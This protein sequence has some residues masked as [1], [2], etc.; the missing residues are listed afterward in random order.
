[1]GPRCSCLCNKDN[2]N[3]YNFY[4]ESAY[5]QL[6]ED[7]P[8]VVKAHKNSKS[9]DIK[10]GIDNKYNRNYFHIDNKSKILDSS[11]SYHKDYT[12]SD[13]KNK[14]IMG[15]SVSDFLNKNMKC[16][17]KIQA[18]A[19]GFITRRRYKKGKN[20]L[21]NELQQAKTKKVQTYLN[22]SIIDAI[23]L[24]RD[25]PF[26]PSRC[27]NEE[28]I[29]QLNKEQLVRFKGVL[30]NAGKNKLKSY[31]TEMYVNSD[32]LYSGYI[33]LDYIKHGYGVQW[34]ST[35]EVYDGNWIDNKFSGYGRYISKEGNV[36]EGKFSVLNF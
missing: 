24:M 18:L 20:G 29:S 1:M 10:D 34:Y 23:K 31:S 4:P 22:Q 27:F 5:L 8:D 30:E 12:G 17:I 14:G 3:N 19:K 13:K 16:I 2:E 26:Y 6:Y 11:N 33:T 9:L 36:L 35:G 15:F 25:K 32:G 28:Y 7:E 21:K